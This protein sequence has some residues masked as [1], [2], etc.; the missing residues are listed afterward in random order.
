MPSHDPARE[1]LYPI[2]GDAPDNLPPE[3]AAGT[4]AISARPNGR[5][6]IRYQSR[7]AA[8][9]F[10][11]EADVYFLP[12]VPTKVLLLCPKCKNALSVTAD[13]KRIE[14]QPP[15]VGHE[16]DGGKISIE[17]FECTWELTQQVELGGELCR[18][19]VAVDNNIARDA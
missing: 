18:W 14:F 8:D 16:G 11:I 7:W 12:G 4:G 17:T 9:P 1:E 3:L 6:F 19:R 2:A 13:R 15:A 5:A 10:V